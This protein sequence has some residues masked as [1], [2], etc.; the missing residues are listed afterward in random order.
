MVSTADS[1][2]ADPDS[3]GPAA[4]RPT[5]GFPV[6]DE[7]TVRG[8]VARARKA[9][10]W[11]REIGHEGRRSRLLEWRR[12][13]ARRLP[14][15]LD[16]LE[17]ENGKVRADAVIE[18]T[19]ALAHVDWAARNARRVLARRRVPSG[20]LMV[21]QLATV[22]Y[23]PY[24][25]IGVIGPWNYPVHTP[26]GSIAYALAAGNTVVFK[27]SEYTPAIGRWLVD[28]FAEA[29]PGRSVLQ[30]TTGDGGTGAA[31]CTSGVDK[32]A[33]TGSPGTGARVLAACAP[34]LT[35]VLLELGGKDALVVAEDAHVPAAVE[36]ALWGGCSNAG[37]SCAGIERVY[38]ADPVY[39]EFLTLL[40]RRA[41][42][43]RAR[44][45]F[46]P[47][48]MPG[49]LEVIRRH[50]EDALSRG[51][52]A[53][54]GGPESVAPP[55]VTGPVILADVPEDSAAVRE[56]T[57]GPVLV[58]NR[59]MDAAEGVERANDSAYGLGAAVFARRRAGELADRL[60][61]G[62]VSVNDVLTFPAVPALPFGGRG[63]S[64]Y[65]RVHG[66]DGLREFAM[67][68][69]R[70]RKLFDVPLAVT[71]YARGARDMARLEGLITW[72]YSR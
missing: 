25:V 36:A 29:V 56:E 70:T 68:T 34:T 5:A 42:E 65:G 51:G 47:I 20:L 52:R 60:N 62:M 57:F 71:T 32:V 12:L 18:M 40:A 27:P 49:Q 43:V 50:I 26:L 31:L 2:T 15:I 39:D 14:E 63:K 35:P 48:T 8:K 44:T 72:L 24:G 6:D 10:S 17:R 59:V 21:N 23:R 67:P 4:P 30:L 13:M 64:G 53:V 58:V 33:F 55:Y 9:T 41:R 7:E 38:V 19:A 22:E 54:V 1:R 45:D 37:Q 46:G 61:A 11:W 66:A 69:A 16:L 28:T 3:L